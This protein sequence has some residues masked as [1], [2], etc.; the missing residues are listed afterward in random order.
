ML[1]FCLVLMVPLL[2]IMLPAAFITESNDKK[3][4][5]KIQKESADISLRKENANLIEAYE[6]VKA[7]IDKNKNLYSQTV[8]IK[9]QSAGCT[10]LM[11]RD[12]ENL[13]LTFWDRLFDISNYHSLLSFTKNFEE[14]SNII[15]EEENVPSRNSSV[16]EIK[17]FMTKKIPLNDIEYF[18]TTGGICYETK[19]SGGGSSIPGAIGG[20]IL[21]G[22]TGAII[23]SRKAVTS[24]QV[25]HDEIKITL[26]YFDKNGNRRF[27][28]FSNRD[29]LFAFETII[30]EK[31]YDVIIKKL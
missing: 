1:I 4:A 2:L 28:N 26:F 7:N 30:P 14:F 6:Q 16:E 5:E 9:S 15:E 18:H 17:H 27:Y 23:G 19:V 10:L 24:E 13:Y 29:S 25:L 22:E 31:A 3:A 8:Y 12:S 20:A 11:Y 21:A